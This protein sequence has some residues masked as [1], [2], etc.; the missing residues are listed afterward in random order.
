MTLFQTTDCITDR[1][2][3]IYS[4]SVVSTWHR[5][6]WRSEQR[7]QCHV[8]QKWRMEIVGRNWED[9]NVYSS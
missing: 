8:W 2:L 1:S 7:A 4:I 5:F 6:V 3:V 9:G